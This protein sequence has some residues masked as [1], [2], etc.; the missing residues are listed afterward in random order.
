MTTAAAVHVPAR[1][2]RWTHWHTGALL[3][4]LAAIGAVGVL[5]P[6][7]VGRADGYDKA[8]LVAW[9]VIFVLMGGFATIAGH[10]ITGLMRGI[11]VDSRNRLSLSRVQMLLWTILVISGFLAAG[12][13]NIGAGDASALDVSIPEPLWLAMGI[14]TTSMVA[15]P[16]ILSRRRRDDLQ[17]KE[18]Q[19]ES[20]WTDIFT[21]DDADDGD[22]LDLGKIQLVFF[23]VALVLAYG[24]ALGHTFATDGKV[25]HSLPPIDEAVV[26]LLTISHAGY[27]TKKALPQKPRQ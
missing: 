13:A 22:R 12:L 14:S 9:L 26:V 21:G 15:S 27:L 1:E 25:V 5:L 4:I 23:T 7:E 16:L 20:R 11:F 24:V 6:R 18:N 3:G 2:P 10:G 19:R 8:R 17:T